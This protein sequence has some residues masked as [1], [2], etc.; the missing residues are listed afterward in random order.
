MAPPSVIGAG[1]GL[2]LQD[3]QGLVARGYGHLPSACFVAAGVEEPRAARTWLRSLAEMVT[4]ASARP[5]DHA[6]QVAF[7]HGGLSK[8]GVK[9]SAADGF[10][11]EFV[12]GMNTPH[13]RRLLGD[14]DANAPEEWAWGGPATPRID[15]LL[16][17]YARDPGELDALRAAQ[18]ERLAAGGLREVVTLPTRELDAFEHFG[19]HDGISQPI[20]TGLSKTGPWADT[21]SAGEFVLGYP[22]EYGLVTSSPLVSAS[23]DPEGLLAAHPSDRGFRDFGRNGTYL[24]LRQLRQHVHRFWRY[25]DLM[26]RASGPAD[27][28]MAPVALA[29]KLVGRWPSGAPLVR[30]PDRDDERLSDSND[31]AYHG[32]DPYGDRCPIG[33]HIRRANP[34]DSLD[35]DPGTRKSVA[36]GKRHRLLRRGRS[37]GP[38]IDLQAALEGDEEPGDERGL[39]FLCLNANIARQFELVQHTWLNNPKFGELYEDPDPLMGAP[40]GAGRTFTLQGSPTRKRLSGMPEFVSVRGGAYFFLPGV[41]A[42]RYLARLNP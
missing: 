22:N 27:D 13:R 38:R 42:L 19:F 28:P 15:V 39:H 11:A 24:V 12:G 37:Y 20:I 2:D 40:V 10:S 34:R 41:A 26:A 14:V 4:P 6:L 29:S 9:P 5:Q 3:I 7:T 1:A 32:V 35:P 25:A 8:L 18:T 16:L 17:F 30:S 21:V 36:V 23:T 31:F 33:A